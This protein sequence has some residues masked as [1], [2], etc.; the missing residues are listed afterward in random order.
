[1][2]RR[3]SESFHSR[4]RH[5]YCRLYGYYPTVRWFHYGERICKSAWDSGIG[6]QLF[7]V[8][9]AET[10]SIIVAKL[11]NDTIDR[12]I[13]AFLYNFVKISDHRFCRFSVSNNS[14]ANT[15]H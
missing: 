9:G 1:L 14:D 7:C 15:S 8:F 3:P 13:S 5:P 4:A 11:I 6:K 2:L 12:L 10:V